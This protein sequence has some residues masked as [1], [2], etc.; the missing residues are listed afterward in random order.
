[1]PTRNLAILLIASASCVGAWALA[2]RTLPGRRFNEVVSLIE[3][4]H[5]DP[6][7]TTALVDAAIETAVD[8]LD[9]HSEYVRGVQRDAL[10]A[11]LDQE[12]SGV[13]LELAADLRTREPLVVTPLPGS[14]AWQ[15]GV[16]AGERVVAIDGVATRGRPLGEAVSRLRGRQGSTVTLTLAAPEP[17]ATL[18]PGSA[19]A[20]STTRDIVLVRDLVRMESVLG[21]RRRADGSWEWRLADAPDIALVRITA[22]GEHTATECAAAL[23]EATRSTAEEDRPPLRGVVLDLR[24]NPGGLLAAAVAVCDQLLEEGVIVTSRSR[25]GGTGLARRATAGDAL[26]GL[27]VA[28]LVDGLTSSAA[29][30]VA[31]CLQDHG[32]ATVVGSRSFGKGTVQALLPLSDG[33]GVLKLTTAEY[34]R[35][36]GAR[37]HRRRV[38]GDDAAWGVMPDAGLEC[39]PTGAALERLRSWRLGR[40]APG[41]EVS[42]APCAI[43]EVLAKAVHRLHVRQAAD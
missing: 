26:E 30:I 42:D 12:F 18:D 2:D 5:L 28:V 4:A 8:R 24:G 6:V 10:E 19:S 3:R 31:A 20:S 36:S 39:T 29:E 14:P 9:E 7:D 17:I 1:M 32:R 27:P 35:P 13:G 21:D 40:D 16:T 11:A 22:F 25:A 43:D 41:A 38:D 34:L 23:A 33:D 15:A 37:L